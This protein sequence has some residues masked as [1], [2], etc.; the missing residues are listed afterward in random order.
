MST[1]AEELGISP[2]AVYIARSR[3]LARLRERV[4]QVTEDSGLD[5]G[6]GYEPEH[7]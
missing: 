3:V 6:D 5:L 1:V 7:L 4:E 2:G